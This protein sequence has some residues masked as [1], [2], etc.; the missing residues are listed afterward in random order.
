MGYD[1]ELYLTLEREY[2]QQRRDDAAD[3][4]ARQAAVFAKVPEL[5][6]V[7]YAIK[8]TGV[9]ISRLVLQKGATSASLAQLKAE[10]QKL[11]TRRK[12]L[13]L[14]NGYPEDELAMRYRCEQCRDT[15][16]VG[17]APCECYRRRLIS[18]AY[19]ASN[20]S[21]MLADQDFAHFDASLYDKVPEPGAAISPRQNIMEIYAACRR[22]VNTFTEPGN[23]LL[24]IGR[25]GVGKTFLST[26]VA[27]E[28]LKHGH[29]V[30]YETAY[31]IFS[32]LDEYKFKRTG[33]PALQKL[34]IDRLYDCDLLILDDLGAEFKTSYTSAALFDVINTRMM[35]GRKCI[36]N[37]NLT[38]AEL[39]SC[40]SERVVSRILG[41]YDILKFIGRD[42]RQ[43]KAGIL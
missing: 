38:L 19:E 39:N 11:R 35:A 8:M 26:C 21:G 20:L 3:L 31:R 14:E 29:S 10:Q 13:L 23:S 36:L 33:D 16:T 15:G 34:Q 41:G 2:E 18:L 1:K 32:L 6:E 24:F 9:S 17:T 37:T 42:I 7:D 22:F 40:Y 27:K 25:P 5:A 28:I 4:E 12:M 43:M 30:I